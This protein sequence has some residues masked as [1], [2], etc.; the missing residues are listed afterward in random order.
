[1]MKKRIQLLYGP[2]LILFISLIFSACHKSAN[3][4]MEYIPKEANVVMSLNIRQMH[5]KLKEGTLNLDSL[6]DKLKT[7]DSAFALL[8]YLNLKI[9]PLVFVQ[10]KSSV[11]SGQDILM[12]SVGQLSDKSG[13]EKE[14][15]ATNPGKSIV[16]KEDYSYLSMSDNSCYV[17][18]DKTVAFY[19]GKNIVDQIPTLF[20]LKKDASLADDNTAIKILSNN[21]DINVYS[22]SQDGLSTIPMLSMTKISDLIKGNYWGATLNFEKGQIVMAG[23]AYY[24][25]TVE[26]L[27]K[28]N[29]SEDVN[30]S[31]LAHFPGKPVA[32]I[33]ISFNLKQLFSFLDYAGVTSMIEGYM[34]N[35]GLTLDDVAKAFTGEIA[36]AMQ[37]LSG[38]GPQNNNPKILTVIPIGDKASYNKVMSALAK[39]GMMEQVDGQWMPKGIKPDDD[40]SFHSDDKNIVFSSDK[41]LSDAYLSGKEKMVY[42]KDLDFS[43]KTTVA[44]VD[45]TTA[46]DQLSTLNSAADS[47]SAALARQ[48]V[49]DMEVSATNIKGNHSSVNFTLRLKDKTQNSLPLMIS[50]FQQMDRIQKANK[51]SIPSGSDSAIVPLPPDLE[52]SAH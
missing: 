13:F 18:N 9:S 5:D 31:V 24:N 3:P 44:Y 36:F 33:Q 12:G 29:P 51:A 49:D 20:K 17:W 38:S 48:T 52:D 28:K 6:M 47:A 40:W 19:G 46:I 26:D 16:K 35:L 39:M 50:T 8:P 1:M 10:Y 43:G 4:G 41:A 23:D 45:M 11:M 2:L 21:G 30:K 34:K 32:L 22:S 15:T 14:L 25:K 7:Q 27:I 37:S 42:P